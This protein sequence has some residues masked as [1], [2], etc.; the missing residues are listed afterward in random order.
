MPS[1]LRTRWNL[2]NTASISPRHQVWKTSPLHRRLLGTDTS[3]GN[4]FECKQER[5]YPRGL[6]RAAPWTPRGPTERL[7]QRPLPPQKHPASTRHAQER[8]PP[9]FP[10][11]CSS[12]AGRSIFSIGFLFWQMKMQ[13]FNFSPST[14]DIY[15][16]SF[17]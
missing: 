6:P 5:L 7:N 3:L 12:G 15:I 4:T 13:L 10:P 16:T 9:S 2:Q 11:A 14:Q 8:R 17:S 1:N